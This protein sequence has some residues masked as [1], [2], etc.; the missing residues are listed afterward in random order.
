MAFVEDLIKTNLENFGLEPFGISMPVV[1]RQWID[2]NNANIN[3][4]I[5]LDE[6]AL[7]LE[8]TTHNWL[9][10]LAG[11]VRKTGTGEFLPYVTLTKSDGTSVK[12]AGILLTLFPQVHNRL[13]RL[14]ANILENDTPLNPQRLRGISVRPVPK[15]FFYEGTGFPADFKGGEVLPKDDIGI[16]GKLMVFDAAG[17][18]MDP[19]SAVAALNAILTKHD[20]LIHKAADP[21]QMAGIAALRAGNTFR[22]RLIDAFGQPYDGSHFMTNLNATGGDASKGIFSVNTYNGTETGV[23][24]EITRETSTGNA[25]AFPDREANFLLIGNTAFGRLLNRVA[26]PTIPAGVTITHEFFTLKIAELQPWL[27]GTPEATYNGTQLEPKPEVRLHEVIQ[28]AADGNT[29]MGHI[30]DIISG[31]PTET[32]LVGENIESAF[33]LPAGATNVRFPD[34]PAALSGGLP[35][36][37]ENAALPADL[38]AQINANSTAAFILDGDHNI[39]V[40]LTLSGVPLGAAIRAFNRKL[41]TD[42][43]EERGDGAGGLV[44]TT[45]PP[46]ADRSFNGQL[47][48]ILKDPLGLK[49]ADGTFT[50]PVN[51]LLNVDLVIVQNDR[52]KRIMGNIELPVTAPVAPPAVTIDNG[53]L[54][55]PKKRGIALS[56][57]LGFTA[58]SVNLPF[59]PSFN[60]TLQAT[61]QLTGESNPVGRDASRLPLMSRRDL[62]AASLTGGNWKGMISAGP[63][64][65]QMHTAE[66]RLGAPGSLGGHE[67]QL[68]GLFTQNGRLAYDL[69]RAAFRRT[70]AVYVRVPDLVSAN[71]NEPA[72]PTAL[73]DTAAQSTAAGPFAGAVLNNIAPNCETPELALLKT[74][75]DGHIGDIPNN[76]DDFVDWLTDKVN[77]INAGGLPGLLGTAAGRLQ[78]QLVTF[79]NNQKDSNSLSESQ[80]ERIYNEL[81]RELSAACYGRRDSQWSLEAGIKSAK[82]FIYIETPGIGPTQYDSAPDFGRDLWQLIADQI[83]ANP[84]LHV[85]IGVPKAPEYAPKYLEWQKREIL[86]RKKLFVTEAGNTAVLPEKRVVVFHPIGFPGRPSLLENHI[87][88]VDDQWMLLGSSAMRRRSLT[89]DGSTDLVIGGFDLEKGI[90]PAIRDFRKQLLQLRLGINDSNRT[91]LNNPNAA[92]LQDGREAFYVVREM[93][94]DGGY[95]LIERLHDGREPHI[96]YVEPTLDKEI[97]NPEGTTFNSLW[98]A[99]FAWLASAGTPGTVFHDV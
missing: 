69:G 98:G 76:F 26:F 54:S 94:K 96:T 27:T 39:D 75:V 58:P 14:Y 31:A 57:I 83:D 82:Q 78:T 52:K 50:V 11:S 7:S 85:I 12:E 68:A 2:L 51:P 28:M 24:R 90:N 53:L 55:N 66:N 35:V 40:L 3:G 95:G 62:L 81:I 93:L 99:F 97:W 18:I 87:V 20:S 22:V 91:S 60:D 46:Q 37:P 8:S 61:L 89:F 15:Y 36:V 17:N 73:N 29:C 92:R 65:R 23:L 49:R 88:I 10:P 43:I 5:T 21:D 38:K 42:F 47:V 34:F 45:L 79:L 32:L 67:T 44:T 80:K 33:N 9:A 1:N 13:C 59:P 63:M 30:G 19:L 84:G 71:W 74:F 48:L 86:E 70:T 16:T 4:E 64:T 6:A 56:G 77:N 25:G 41:G 72:T